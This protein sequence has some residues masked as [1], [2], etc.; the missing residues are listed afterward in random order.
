MRS[1]GCMPLDNAE[2]EQV[3]NKVDDI[4]LKKKRR[5][6]V[7]LKMW[8]KGAAG[9]NWYLEFKTATVK[10]WAVWLSVKEKKKG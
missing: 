8:I 5:N 4:N 6:R 7:S 2:G 3:Q 1:K 9:G 10:I